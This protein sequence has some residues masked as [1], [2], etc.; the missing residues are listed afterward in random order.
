ME[1]N[2]LSWL[3]IV[4]L[5][6][7]QTALGAIVVL[8]TSTLN[9]VMVVE[10]ALPA[11]LPGALI[12]LHHAMQMLRPRMGY[13]SD[14]GQRH[15]P[16]VVLGMAALALGG[17]GATV[18]T[19]L[20]QAYFWPALALA[21]LSFAAIGCGVSASGTSILVL[22]AKRVDESRRAAAATIVWMMMIAGFAITAT[23]AGKWLDPFTP[24]RLLSVVSAVC[25]GAFVLSVLAMWGVEGSGRRA[26]LPQQDH[27]SDFRRALAQVWSEPD[28]RRFT[29]FVFVS[30]FSYSAQD[31]ILEPFAGAIFGLTPGESTSLSG[32]QHAGVF[33]GMLLV[34]VVVSL[35]KGTVLASLKGWVTWGCAA[36]GLCML[37]LVWAGISPS[38]WPLKPNVFLLGLSNGVFSIAAISSMMALAQT[39]RAAQAE[40]EGTR[41][42]LWG[43]AQAISF[44]LGSVSGTILVDLIKALTGAS[45]SAYACVFMLEALGFF[46][47]QGLA[48][49]TYFPQAFAAISHTAAVLDR[50]N[51]P[52]QP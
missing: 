5:G 18:A 3:A 14:V 6:V 32:T 34:A 9:R 39:D 10:L 1:N 40:R 30:M 27:K 11:L 41:M 26:A 4:R 24:G 13:G 37:G 8:M 47:A 25:A 51:H 33:A 44:A 7:A 50:E 35:G 15:T 2:S 16:W 52:A 23:F 49:A 31:L 17:V 19:T 46:A 38:G 36:S 20:L 45:G 12:T 29:L 21:T 43:A 48:R 42:G 22:M 28:A